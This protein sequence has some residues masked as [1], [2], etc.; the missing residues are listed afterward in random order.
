MVHE[1]EGG[2]NKFMKE[3]SRNNAETAATTRHVKAAAKNN[4]KTFPTG[5]NFLNAEARVTAPI[6]SSDQVK[7]ME[8]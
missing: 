8:R 4:P 3:W 2:I 5:R 6:E 7:L 1:C